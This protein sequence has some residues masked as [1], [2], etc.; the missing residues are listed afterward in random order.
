MRDGERGERKGVQRKRASEVERGRERGRKGE[1]R[2]EGRERGRRENVCNSLT[3]VYT[4]KGSKLND[5][6]FFSL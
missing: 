6:S 5:Q 3:R 2:G 1:K 4:S